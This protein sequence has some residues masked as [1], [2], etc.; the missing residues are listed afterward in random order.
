MGLIRSLFSEKRDLSLTNPKAWNPSLWNLMGSQSHAGVNVNEDTALNYSAVFNAIALISGTV[1]TLPLHLMRKKA[2]GQSLA[3]DKRV[4]RVLHDIANP[5]MTAMT[6]KEVLT[7]HILAWGNCYAEKV[8]DDRNNIYE[9]WPIAPNRVRMARGADR[10]LRYVI[11][12]PSGEEIVLRRDKILH[13]PGLGF[14]GWQGYSVITRARES[15]GLG[16]AAE[17]FGALHFGSGTH[18][19]V[20]V[21]HP[22][23]LSQEAHDNLKGDLVN[24][25]SGLGKSHRL[26]LLEEGM[27]I[28]KIGFSPE[29]SQFLETRQ[30]QIPEIARWFNLPPHKLKDLTKS[31][32]NNIEQ[33]QISFVTD[34][35]LP[36]LVRFE[37]HYNMQLLTEQER[38]RKLYFKHIVEGLLRGDAESRGNFYNQMFMIGGMS[39]NEIREK[40]DLNPIQGGDEHF[41]PLN[42]I[43][44]ES[45]KDYV[46]QSTQENESQNNDSEN[47]L[48]NQDEEQKATYRPKEIRSILSRDRVVRRYIPLFRQAAQDIVNR[49]G[50][51][52]K[53]KLGKR[54]DFQQWLEN[55]Y[56]D[57]PAYIKRKLGPVFQSFAE[58]IRD[59][60]VDEIGENPKDFESFVRD[61]IDRYIER[62]I[63]SSEGQLISLLDEGDEALETRVDEWAETRPD[64]IALNETTR[65]SSAV[66]Q[67]VAFGAGLGTYWRIRGKDTCPYCKEFEGR[68]VSNGETFVSD[69]EELNPKDGTGPMKV[70]G[71][72]A[73]PPLHQGCDCY[74]SVG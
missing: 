36:W 31:S 14:D 47:D 9:L 37:Q 8:I 63:G 15:I 52:I 5:E 60:S 30:F 65:M 53:K 40:E 20:V 26:L 43:P 7:A 74:L 58:S 3:T 56:R 28:E 41:V 45:A 32:F 33:E 72:K 34:S 68:K 10:Q 73:H 67:M 70:R 69:G 12:M 59:I 35:I 2:S 54:E 25:Y 22:S 44:L 11:K 17:E 55:F 29:D 51:A 27:S 16:M 21:S 50:V 57:L 4:Y 66:Y 23:K 6:L 13:V 38:N 48:N 49:E 18:P 62:H 64:K 24:K 61:Y 39:I 42:M 19:G 71:M 46:M 1:A